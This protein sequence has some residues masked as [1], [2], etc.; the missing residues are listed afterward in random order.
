MNDIEFVPREGGK[1]RA[2]WTD[3]HAD[4]DRLDIPVEKQKAFFSIIPY[5]AG[6]LAYQML[7]QDRSTHSASKCMLCNARKKQWRNDAYTGQ[8]L[9]IAGFQADR[10]ALVTQYDDTVDKATYPTLEAWL[11]PYLKRQH[12][13]G[14][15]G[16]D[17]LLS[18]IPVEDY[19]APV[20]HITLG[21][22]S[23]VVKRVVRFMAE[24]LDRVPAAAEKIPKNSRYRKPVH[25]KFFKMLEEYKISPKRYYTGQLTGNDAHRLLSNHNEICNKMLPIFKDPDLRKP[26]TAADIDVQVDAFIL[27]LSNLLHVY[28]VVY[29]LMTRTARLTAAEVRLFKKMCVGFGKLWRHAFPNCSVPPKVHLVESHLPAQMKRFGCLGDKSESVVERCHQEVNKANKILSACKDY[30]QKNDCMLSI[31]D[32]ASDPG[33]VSAL[34][35]VKEKTTRVVTPAKAARKLAED[36]S[37]EDAKKTIVDVAS[38]TLATIQ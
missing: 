25:D 21:V 16:C 7:L 2:V 23:S 11:T 24:N 31:R 36:L 14:F 20:L 10:A 22:V 1:L 9:T 15:R 3:G 19:L 4:F 8:P 18:A 28:Q 32:V 5:S 38:H 6:D 27:N 17:V 30:E 33:V 13:H 12:Q 37:M 34:R 29:I 26:D 35:Y